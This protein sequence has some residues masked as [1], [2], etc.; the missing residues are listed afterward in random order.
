M[1]ILNE[2]DYI[3]TIL[4]SKKKPE[5]LSISLLVTLI[6]KYYYTPD[7]TIQSLEEAVKETMKEFL[8][9]PMTYQEY[10]WAAKIHTICN[11]LINQTTD[12]FLLERDFIPVYT[13][14]MELIQSCHNDREMKL[15]FTLIVLARYM[16]CDGWVNKKTLKGWT[17]IFKL[18][19]ITLSNEKKCEL[20]HLLYERGLISMSKKVDNLNMKVPLSETGDIVYKV[21]SFHNL[22]NQYIG[23]FKKGY[24]QCICCGKAIKVTGNK[25]Q[26]CNQ[27]AANKRKESWSTAS[28]K[29]RSNLKSS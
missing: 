4:I 24:K 8:F 19:N 22:G 21:T 29:Y 11:G 20:I 28:K 15:L 10:K 16:N 3:Q 2:K 5:D 6:A 23:N 7:I 13:S 18:A 14:D 27:C 12:G 9:P 26:L 17:E 25:K 1:Y